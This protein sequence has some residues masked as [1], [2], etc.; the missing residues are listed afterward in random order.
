MLPLA[1]ATFHVARYLLEFSN[2]NKSNKQNELRLN[3]STAVFSAARMAFED[4]HRIIM[5][6][7]VHVFMCSSQTCGYL[8]PVTPTSLR[9]RLGLLWWLEPAAATAC[10]PHWVPAFTILF[11]LRLA[12]RGLPSE[13]HQPSLKTTAFRV[14]SRRSERSEN[15]LCQERSLQ[16]SLT[17]LA[18]LKNQTGLWCMQ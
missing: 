4:L 13:A 10:F 1:Y 12:S 17:E 9:E 5:C 14:W 7:C 15:V 2:P 3:T 18:F 11:S 16:L 6:S 8:L